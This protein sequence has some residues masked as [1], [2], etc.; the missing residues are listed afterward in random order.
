MERA[1]LNGAEIE[2]QVQGSGE[3]VL[4]IHGSILADAFVP[5][6]SQPVLRSY[7]L[8]SYH[9]R[10]F[11]GSTHPNGA[12]VSISQH[13]GDA[14][15]LLQHLGV[16]RAHVAGHSYGAV[17]G[18]Q[19]ALQSPEMVHTLVLLEP[20][21][22]TGAQAADATASLKSFEDIYNSGK[23]TEAL[24]A[25]MTNVNGAD[26]RNSIEKALGKRALE[27]AAAD[28]DT[29]F[30]TEVP[31]LADW[32]F[33]PENAR[34]IEAPVLCMTGDDSSPFFQSSHELLVT[35]FVQAYQMVIYRATHLLQVMQPR[36]VAEALARY[37]S[38]YPMPV[39]TA[40]AL[41]R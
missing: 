39:A 37:L 9:R 13:A 19:L 28:V 17:I 30:Q 41:K 36:A 5:L 38:R 35:W 34:Q 33:T 25:F 23:K 32:Q 6:L 14:R 22:L 16:T 1:K 10:G 15:A 31:A 11:A 24:D 3:P 21:I 20:P 40:A 2:Y 4:L 26:Y 8:I 27:Q 29:F 7:R 12:P 18:L